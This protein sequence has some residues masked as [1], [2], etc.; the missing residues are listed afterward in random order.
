MSQVRR[1]AVSMASHIAEIDSSS[2]AVA[3]YIEHRLA[4]LTRLA[5]SDLRLRTVLELIADASSEEA[6]LRTIDD[7]PTPAAQA[8]L[9]QA[10]RG[11]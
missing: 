4:L 1:I 9:E 2:S 10:R 5:K 7:A 11:R 8:E 6:M 3:D